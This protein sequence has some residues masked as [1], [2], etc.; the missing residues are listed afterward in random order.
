MEIPP[1]D[2]T[3]GAVGPSGRHLDIIFDVDLGELVD[4][5]RV[6]VRGIEHRR[7]EEVPDLTTQIRERLAARMREGA[8][9]LEINVQWLEPDALT[10]IETKV[11]FTSAA[12]HFEFVPGLHE[13]E[14]K[15]KGPFF[16]HWTLQCSDDVGTVYDHDNGG[17]FDPR[18]GGTASHGMRDL[19]GQIPGHAGR[20]TIDFEPAEAWHPQRPWRHQLVVDLREGRVIDTE[21]VG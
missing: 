5:H 11:V 12:L 7:E 21:E 20:L 14:Q 8:N 15:E 4:G 19:G 18:G 17:A 6:I 1:R 2:A 16:W 3:D 10:S 13:S 9:A